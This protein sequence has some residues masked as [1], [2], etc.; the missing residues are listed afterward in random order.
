[1]RRVLL[2]LI[3][4]CKSHEPP[5]PAPA[6]APAVKAT[7]AFVD[8]TVVAMDS[9]RELEHQTVLVDGTKIV[10]IGP[11]A[12]TQVPAQ[13]AKIDGAGKWLVPGLVDMHVHFNDER[14]GLLFVA[15]GVTTVRNMW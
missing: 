10:A 15:N 12:S 4:A 13:A 7:A 1:M 9:E 3:A 5:P 14:Y 8:V 11:T 2:V 6:P